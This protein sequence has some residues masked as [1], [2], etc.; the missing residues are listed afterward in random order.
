MM[1]DIRRIFNKTSWTGR[2]LGRLELTNMAVTFGQ[3]LE[4]EPIKPLF[5]VDQFRAMLSTLT[6]RKQLETY[7]SYMDIHKWVSLQYQISAG[8]YQNL[9]LQ[10]KTLEAYT[11]EAAAAE[12]FYAYIENKDYPYD[13]EI[14]DIL[15]ASTFEKFF[16]EAERHEH[17]AEIVGSS[18]ERTLTAYY[19]LQGYNLALDMTAKRHSVSELSV[20][21]MDLESIGK[22]TM[23]LNAIIESLFKMLSRPDY[24]DKML[25]AKKLQVLNELFPI[26]DYDALE[27][28]SENIAEAKELV[29][30]FSAYREPHADR[31]YR[32][33]CTRKPG[34]PSPY[35]VREAQQ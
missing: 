16:P 31:F 13:L 7:N 24:R 1:A 14:A 12:K 18:V 21:K 34:E 3:N 5:T 22:I 28:P 27:I 32:L 19:A 29:N 8:Y 20:F 11:A 33:L 30:T 10:L 17:H 15:A 2:E 25:Q 9:Q 26:I 6:D 35:E 23:E 4:G